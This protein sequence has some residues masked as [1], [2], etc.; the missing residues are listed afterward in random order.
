MVKVPKVLKDTLF[1]TLKI[2][3]S[4]KQSRQEQCGEPVSYVNVNKR[5]KT[6]LSA[7]QLQ[8]KNHI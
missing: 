7:F 3:E 4:L 5:K 1:W 8:I 2:Y 6:Q